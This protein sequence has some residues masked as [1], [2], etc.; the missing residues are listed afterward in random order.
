MK[1][2]LLSL[3]L[4]VIVGMYLLKMISSG[5]R[6]ICGDSEEA[7]LVIIVKDQEPWMESFIRKLFR[8]MKNTP[9]VEVTVVDDCSQDGTPEVLNRLQKHYPFEFV[10]VKAG[11]SAETASEAGGVKGRFADA[12]CFNLSGLKGKDLLNASLFCHLSHLNAGKSRLLS[13]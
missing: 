4:L 2:F 5:S 9:Q 11:S 13:K 7:W 3:A 6:D 10:P 1:V 12:M 8:V